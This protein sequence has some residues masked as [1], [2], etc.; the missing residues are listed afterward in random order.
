ML[1]SQVAAN[2]GSYV[3]VLEENGSKR[4]IQFES[5]F[6]Y[7]QNMLFH[8]Q[9]IKKLRTMLTL[10]HHNGPAKTVCFRKSKND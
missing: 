9:N 2:V 1:N 6:L 10:F 5:G 3:M 4:H 8:L 7:N